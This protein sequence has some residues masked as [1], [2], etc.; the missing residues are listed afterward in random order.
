[1]NHGL[2]VR[3]SLLVAADSIYAAVQT[4]FAPD[5]ITWARIGRLFATLERADRSYPNDPQ[6]QYRIGE[7][8]THTPIFSRRPELLVESFARAVELDSTF[9]PAYPHLYQLQI[10]LQDFEGSRRSVASFL[11]L[12]PT[13]GQGAGIRITQAFLSPET[14]TPGEVESLLDTASVAALSS[15]MIDAQTLADSSEWLIRLARARY[16]KSSG[17]SDS[18]TAGGQLAAALAFRGHLQESMEMTDASGGFWDRYLFREL[19]LF[20][21]VPVERAA[22]VFDMWLE[23]GFSRLEFPLAWWASAGDT[24][25]IERA[26]NIFES[27]AA[28]DT[29]RQGRGWAEW[30]AQTAEFYLALARRDTA[31]ALELGEMFPEYDCNVTCYLR[32]LSRAQLLAASGRVAEAAQILEGSATDFS[33]FQAPGDVLWRLERARIHDRLGNSDRAITDYSFVANVWR[34]ADD[35]LQPFVTESR[36]ALVRLTG[37]SN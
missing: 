18:A 4:T 33:N 2:S 9:A 1:M 21:A 24:V 5:S 10:A 37:E 3:E 11:G 29:S 17:T 12:G 20:G 31:L 8:R 6:I 27:G 14:T 32:R 7:A 30:G 15:A 13:G 26:R 36:E 19:A 28:S 34:H 16:E 35:L 22:I 25:A 23:D